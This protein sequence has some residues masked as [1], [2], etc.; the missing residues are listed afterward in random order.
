MKKSYYDI[1]GVERQ[2]TEQEVRAAYRRL[3]LKY[4]PDRNPDPAATEMFLKITRAYECLSDAGRRA[5]YDRLLKLEEQPAA[6][7]QTASRTS[8]EPARTKTDAVTA[9]RKKEAGPTADIM[10]LTTLLNRNKYVEAEGL[11]RRLMQYY[12]QEALPYAVLGDI[13]RY[14]G[15][16]DEASKLY[17]Y[18]AQ[19]DPRNPV[20][21]K[22]HEEMLLATTRANG[23]DTEEM[24]TFPLMVGGGI[25]IASGAYLALSQEKP[26][27]AEG[28]IS[29]W[30]LGLVV[31][32]FLCGVSMGACMTLSGLLDRFWAYRGAA[33]MRFPPSLILGV[34]ALANFWAALA[35]YLGIGASQNAFNPSTSRIVTAVSLVTGL[36]AMA[37]A[38]SHA[39]DRQAMMGQTMLW[40]GNLVYLGAL[41]GWM[42]ADGFR[43]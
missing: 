28:P 17:A 10:R 8:R 14:R 29:Q 41:C 21:Q 2:A 19:M 6:P 38:M 35:L 18:A 20:F 11:A 7:Q 30:T 4:H 39:A 43:E 40:G 36:L 9:R 31:M 12:P 25:V 33:V 3:V 37:T 13:S 24:T 15:D 26:L 32:L 16:L 22:K 23:R 27:Y 34:V 5:S 42:V 1:L